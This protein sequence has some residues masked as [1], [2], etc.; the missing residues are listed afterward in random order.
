[1]RRRLLRSPFRTDAIELRIV[2]IG[3]PPLQ[4]AINAHLIA[5][6]SI[7]VPAPALP[8]KPKFRAWQHCP[9]RFAP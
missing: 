3:K 1:M 5:R 8:N 2:G 7:L 6:V 4:Y 9:K